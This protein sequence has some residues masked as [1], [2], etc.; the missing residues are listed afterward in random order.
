MDILAGKYGKKIA[1][2]ALYA[3]ALYLAF[4]YLFGLTAPFLI[5]L[6][7]VYLCNPLLKKVQKR[8]HIRR[9]I[10]L[11]GLLILALSLLAGCLWGMLSFGTVHAAQLGESVTLLQ[12]KMNTAL[13][14]GCLFLE[15]NWG[16]DAAQTEKM[17]WE[18]L[19]DLARDMR[20]NMGSEAARRSL[21][22]CRSILA[23]AAFLGIS[24]IASLL[25]CRDYE[26]ILRRLDGDPIFSLL[27]KFWQ[28]TVSLI[29]G[30][31][32]AQGILMLLI[33]LIA[34]VGLLIGRVQGALPLAFL[35]GVL[36]ALPFI[37]SGTVLLPTALWQLLSGNIPGA[38][39]A[40]IAF[41][42]C[43]VFRELLEPRLLGKQVGLFPVVMLFFV[44][45]GVKLFGI[46]GIFSGPLYAVLFREGAVTLWH[47]EKTGEKN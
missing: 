9:E 28:K 45:A 6:L 2:T 36:D 5:A 30:Y 40:V 24:F 25:L 46:F 35:T 29:G 31:L 17:L 22:C 33:M 4:R 15:K 20:Q 41:V 13:H 23:A 21:A 44:Y 19:N 3:A 37:G 10:L 18:R 11:G 14:D 38:C 34:A 7:I 8:T 42:F 47:A 39:G 26:K 43:I 32:R 27:W 1:Y 16:L 12:D